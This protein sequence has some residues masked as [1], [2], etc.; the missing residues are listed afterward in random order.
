VTKQTRPASIEYFSSFVETADRQVATR[1][2]GPGSGFKPG[3]RVAAFVGGLLAFAAASG[4][5]LGAEELRSSLDSQTFQGV[6][7]RLRSDIDYLAS[8]ELAGRHVGSEGLEKAARYI[9]E[10]F[11]RSGLQT[12]LYEQAPFQKLEIVI[13]SLLGDPAKN[14]FSIEP[15]TP[16]A[17][18]P[19]AAAKAVD[20]PAPP[21][22][23]R[24]DGVVDEDFRPL[25][26]GSNAQVSGPLVFAGYGVTEPERNYD[27]YANLPARGAIVMVLRKEPRR[28]A[29]VGATGR[30]RESRHAFFETKIRSAAAQGAVAVCLINDSQSIAQS[31][32]AIESRIEGE[33]KKVD[34]LNEKI[35]SLPAEANNVREQLEKNR[36]DIES[37]VESLRG[38]RD[39]TAAGLLEIA[40]A[41]NRPFVD[42]IPVISI[43]RDVA[44]EWIRRSSGKTLDQ[45]QAEIDETTKP[46]SVA[47]AARAELQSD[48]TEAVVNS[49][50]VIGV[51]PG[52]GRLAEQTVIVGAHYDHVGMGGPGSLAPGTVAIHN[53][54]DDNASGTSVMLASVD[55]I[56]ADLA[57]K[58]EHRRVVFIA[59]TGEERGLLG[60]AHYVKNPRFPLESTVAMINL[61]MVGRLRDNDLTVYGTG[62]SPSFEELLD[63]ANQKTG[64][65]LFKVPSGYGPSD[66]QSFYERNIPVLFFFTGLHADYH[67]PS[68]KPD[69]VNITGMARIADLT[70][71]VTTELATALTPPAYAATTRDVRIR[72]Q[73]KPYLGVVLREVTDQD[74]REAETPQGV[75][76]TG[77]T[78][79]S[80]AEAAGVMVGDRLTRIDGV[81]ITSIP[82]LIE[83]IGIRETDVPVRIELWRQGTRIEATA[84]LRLRED[85]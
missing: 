46:Q 77:I 71:L 24:W 20:E 69:K 14:R 74:P 26:I 17:S 78:P 1:K 36:K 43:S 73:P 6:L 16:A 3:I 63:R 68:D 33:M 62:T 25:A 75:I 35:R 55:R 15:T 70:T 83:M 59:F 60:S 27:D 53:G 8:D 4:S 51:L 7:A 44:S 41:G 67:R 42:G 12:D 45:I 79:Q 50:N 19:A 49:S 52:R 9:Q 57:G 61:D 54:A 13:G 28:T 2:S 40:S 18:A 72:Q 84:T 32:Q 58:E 65:S 76:A 30:P 22:T 48:V 38:E 29:A 10:S 31:R 5:W 39:R 37:M 34:G 81:G 21:Q 11:S 80:P 23:A 56:I 82:D 85:E 47:L 64:F 66:H